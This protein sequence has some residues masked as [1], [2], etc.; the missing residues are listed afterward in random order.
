M[1][2][3][4][5]EVLEV[6]EDT[7][8]QTANETEVVEEKPDTGASVAE[9]GTIKLDLGKLNKPQEDAAQGQSTDDSG[10]A[11]GKPEDRADSEEVIEE[12]RGPEE[13]EASVLE[14]VTEEEEAAP[15][16]E[17]TKEIV[18]EA[19]AESNE[20]G[21]ALPENIQKVVDFMN[22]TGGSLED[23]V[24]LNT[25]Y[26]KLNEVQLIREYYENTKPHLDKEDID[27]LMED[28]S[29]DEELDD[30]R[31]IKK[32]KI[33][34]KEEAAKAKNHLESLKSQYYEN[35][36]AGSNL[37]QD[38]Q[39][40]VDFFNRYSKESEEAT[41]I[42]ESQKK[43]FLTETENVFNENFKG[44][45]YSVGDKKYRF[46]IK[47]TEDVK[48]TQSDINNFV[49]KFLNDRNEMSDAKGYHK[50]LFTAM[51]ADAIANHFYEQGKADA[52]KE[53]MS[54]TKNVDMDPRRGHEKVTT[55]NGWTIRAVPSDA[56]STSSF[57]VKKRK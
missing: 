47:N 38:Q 37:T 17:E 23:Y 32:A 28:F 11:I 27:T 10:A 43:I 33:A 30:P 41:K 16:V 13:K 44:F 49:K 36:K 54:R 51:N 26:S 31:D 46:K 2:E 9:D 39:K 22:E 42:A 45:D 55:S 5:E 18:E 19:V 15:T 29:Y 50:S 52:V 6:K 1:S 20:T 24:K 53:S 21:V 40:A 35:I 8:E 34:F 48:A 12:A 4:Q 56:T 3:N 25:D 57:R 14:E 7:Q